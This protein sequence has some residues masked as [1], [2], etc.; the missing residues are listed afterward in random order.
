MNSVYVMQHYVWHD[1]KNCLGPF[2]LFAR[3]EDA[4]Q[5]L[6]T[7]G[8]VPHNIYDEVWVSSDDINKVFIEDAPDLSKEGILYHWIELYEAPVS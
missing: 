1:R 7:S 3:K 4:E 8:H 6:Y 5:V 2:F